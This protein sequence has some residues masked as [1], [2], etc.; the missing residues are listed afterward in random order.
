[1]TIPLSQLRQLITPLPV[2]DGC[3]IL[4]TADAYWLPSMAWFRQEYAP[5]VLRTFREFP[6]AENR[7]DCNQAVRIALALAGQ[8]MAQRPENAAICVGR[9]IGGLYGTVNGITGSS[10]VMHDTCLIVMDDLIPRFY[11]PQN[12]YL[13]LAADVTLGDW[14]ADFVEL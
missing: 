5:L 2:F 12:G 11:E 13:T 1:M 14:A 3:R 6:A 8:A 7:R 10:G 4:W 9:T